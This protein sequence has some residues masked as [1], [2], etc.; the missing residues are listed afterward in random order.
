MPP[1][2]LTRR[3]LLA[4]GAS[5]AALPAFAAAAPRDDL[6]A[7]VV[8]GVN[9][10]EGREAWV[11]AHVS[12]AGLKRRPAEAWV[13]MLDGLGRASGGLD[14]V[15][16]NRVGE[17]PFPLVRTRMQRLERTL[18]L[19]PDRTDPSRIFDL[20]DA[21]HPTP[22]GPLPDRPL[23][24]RALAAALRERVAFAARRDE[25]SGV[26]RVVDPAGALVFEAAHGVA[27][28]DQGAPVRPDSRFNLGSADKSFTALLIA[29][30]VDAG[31]L[32][33]DTP[34]AEVMPDYANR[35]TAR[36]VTVRHLLTHSA[37]LG[38]LWSR[39][40]YD[41]RKRY[42][43]VAEIV[44]AFWDAA[45]A[46]PPGSRGDYSNEGFVL[47]GALAERVDGRSWWDQLATHVYA[48]AG[49][50]RSAHYTLDGPAPARAVGYR[51]GEGDALGLNGRSAN[52]SFLGWRGNSCGGGYSTAADMTGYL[53]AL[54][55][56]R[57][58]APGQADQFTTQNTG[59]LSSYG[60][61]F[62]HTEVGGRTV[63][64]HSGGGPASGIN[65]DAG[66]VWETGW[67]YAVM[68][69]YDA[70]FAQFLGGDIGRILAAQA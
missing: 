11:A 67:A 61:G 60:M 26:V 65:M 14:L 12:P 57:L 37:G 18:R 70:P 31:R 63:R 47:L 22:F 56:G 10:A 3:A 20:M 43:R 28:Q 50:T 46:F 1:H 62:I 25:F 8:E 54:R 24:R 7:A 68:G 13:K 5:A 29:R 6:A 36:A 34:V 41:G 23:S 42:A 48:P 16:V 55:A 30:L 52:W 2:A 9:R 59:G 51:F 39:P 64:G 66:I 33:L 49:M 40:A 44:P 32:S 17:A 4:A 38:D 69:N 53:H 45:P 21:P 19:R 35:E 58:C 15:R 27:D